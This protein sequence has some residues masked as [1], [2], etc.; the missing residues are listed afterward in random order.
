MFNHKCKI[1]LLYSTLFVFLSGECGIGIYDEDFIVG[2]AIEL[3][4]QDVDFLVC[5]HYL[6]RNIPTRLGVLVEVVFPFILLHQR[7][8]YLLLF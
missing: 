3:I 1:G 7:E 4:Y 5:L 6:M 8:F 2:E